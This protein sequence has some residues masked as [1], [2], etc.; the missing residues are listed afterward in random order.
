MAATIRPQL[1][2][3]PNSAVLTSSEVARV[4]AI[5]LASFDGSSP[6]SPEI[7]PILLRLL[8]LDRFGVLKKGTLRSRDVE[9][10]QASEDFEVS[11]VF[12][13]R[14]LAR[15]RTV[16]F[17]LASPSTEIQLN[18][19]LTAW[20]NAVWRVGLVNRHI[21]SQKGEHR[22]HIR[23]NHSCSLSHPSNCDGFPSDAGL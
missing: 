8:H 22:R 23:V 11:G 14:P 20:C 3:S 16:S 4:L 10:D 6:P 18:E 1:G 15:Q 19:A 5:R 17:V 13:A 21:G 2:S 7:L 12:S 9:I